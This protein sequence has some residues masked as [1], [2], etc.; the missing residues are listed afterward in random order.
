MSTN[1]PSDSGRIFRFAGVAFVTLPAFS[2]ALMALAWLRFGLDLPFRDD[3]REYASGKIA[4]LDLAHLF[5]SDNDT[6]SVT[7]RVFDALAQRFLDG[8][9]IAYQLLSMLAVL[10]ILLILQWKLLSHVLQNRLLAACA[11]ASTLLM[12]QPG[13]YWGLQNMAYIQAV[14]VACLLG[15]LYVAFVVGGRPTLRGAAAFVIAGFSGITY[16]SGALSMLAMTVLLAAAALRYRELRPVL[17]I[18][19]A[20][21]LTAASITSALQL[22]VIVA[23]QHGQTHRADAPW[24]L[25]VDADFWFYALGKVGRSLMLPLSTPTISMLTAALMLVASLA[26]A[27]LL[28]FRPGA[29]AAIPDLAQRRRTAGLILLCLLGAIGAYLA[30]VAAGRANLRPA[31]IDSAIEIFE[32]GYQRFHFF[33]VTVLWPWL[34][35]SLM[36]LSGPGRGRNPHVLGWCIVA[37]AISLFLIHQGAMG[38]ASTFRRIATER[39]ATDLACLQR[40]LSQGDGLVCP[41]LAPYGDLSN[42]YRYA[43]RTGASFVRYVPP[44][45]LATNPNIRT[46]YTD[47]LAR[48]PKQG[49]VHNAKVEASSPSILRLSGGRDAQVVFSTGEAS[50]LAACLVLQVRASIR[51]ENFDRVQLF[52][53]EPGDAG[54]SEPRSAKADLTGRQVTEA[55]FVLLSQ[56][57]FQDRFRLDPVANFQGSSITGLSMRCLL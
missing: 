17:A 24:A 2:L 30:M 52:Y 34:L 9:S 26:V 14:P 38:H 50:M 4:S 7:T 19:A 15:L 23:V 6:L 1:P 53:L 46:P 22:H 29:H 18:P 36:L 48:L 37:L 51:V 42:A 5:R 43:V 3:W 40:S 45:L 54:F 57:G 27:A 28:F 12:L 32:F 47:L 21:A 10:G 56:T 16:I 44:L 13:S 41:T 55:S 49:E 33:W 11:F 35:A 31:R 39:T 20:S 25:P 8:N